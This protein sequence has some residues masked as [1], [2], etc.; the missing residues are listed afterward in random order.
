MKIVIDSHIPYIKG[1]LDTY[2]DVVYIP[3]EKIDKAAIRD[4]DILIIRTPTK[5]TPALLEGSRCKYIATASIGFDHINTPYCAEHGI[6]WNNAPGCN[7][8]SVAQYILCS[9]LLFLKEKQLSPADLKVGIIGAGHVGSAVAHHLKTVGFDVLLNDPLRAEDEGEDSFVT[10]EEIASRCDIIS[11]HTPLTKSGKFST[12]HLADKCFFNSLKRKPLFI[13]SARGGVADDK[14]LLAAKLSG[15]ICGFIIDCWENEPHGIYL[16]L[17][18]EAFIATP[19]IA[20]YSDDG[21][22]NGSH[23][24][25]N[26]VARYMGIN[27]DKR[28]YPEL[29]DNNTIDLQT[30]SDILLSAV[31]R[32]YDPRCDSALLKENPASFEHFRVN[33]PFRREFKAYKVVNYGIDYAAILKELGFV[34]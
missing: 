9:L 12:Y 22:A 7:S 27:P 34:L 29:P 6:L 31:L 14:A 10:L 3:A 28:L 5:C 19:H 30:E 18:D 11:L 1:V 25:V 16:P 24:V 15:K 21:K 4:A 2:A 33:Y 32:S 23:I 13:N 8:Y 26:Q 20:G 17:L